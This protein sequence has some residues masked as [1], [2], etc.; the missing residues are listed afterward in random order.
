M[1]LIHLLP[2]LVF[3]ETIMVLTSINVRNALKLIMP[4]ILIMSLP[5]MVGIFF[6]QVNFH[7]TTIVN[8]WR[9]NLESFWYYQLNHWM[10]PW[11]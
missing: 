8:P 6:V 7:Q 1:N 10:F 11:P 9:L 3:F 4:I 2:I 5:P